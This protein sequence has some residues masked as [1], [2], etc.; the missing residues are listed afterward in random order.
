MTR[1]DRSPD[2]AGGRGV[3]ILSASRACYEHD[4]LP[5]G[6]CLVD[7]R[8]SDPPDDVGEH[9]VP[10]LYDHYK[11]AKKRAGATAEKK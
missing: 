8:M 10:R 1:R 7:E 2:G 11:S 6:R 4:R 3:S 5:R 9:P